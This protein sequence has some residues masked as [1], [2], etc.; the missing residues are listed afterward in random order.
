MVIYS[1][2]RISVFE[3]C[4][5]R[6]KYKY[7]EKLIPEFER[8]IESHL[9]DI[10]HQTLEWFYLQIKSGIIPA[11]DEVADYYSR[12]WEEHYSPEIKNIKEELTE[13]D[14]FNKGIKFL[15]DYYMKNKPFDE[16]TIEVEK[17]VIINLGEKGEH[18]LQGFIDR[19][20]YNPE[21]D[22]FEIHDYKTANNLPAKKKIKGD[23][24]LALYSIAIRELFGKDKK[25]CLVWHYLSHN[26]KICERKTDEEIQKLKDEIIRLIRK[27]E[28]EKEFPAKKSRLCQWCGYRKICP[29]FKPQTKDLDKF[30]TIRKYIKD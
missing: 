2:S 4:P 21:K 27:I 18:K 10:I 3:Q 16:N 29:A 17:K 22:E 8:T 23:K 25:I 26:L 1:Y 12:K 11:I 13:K 14:Y 9:G 6:F 7:V 19:L 24:Q 30:P 5:L 28:T 15:V 20:A